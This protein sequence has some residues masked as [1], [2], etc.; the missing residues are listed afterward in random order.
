ME[1]RSRTRLACLEKGKQALAAGD[2]AGAI[3][4]FQ[5]AV[6]ITSAMVYRVIQVRA[7]LCVCG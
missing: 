4:F 7:A 5:K 2:R 6:S 3:G 1:E